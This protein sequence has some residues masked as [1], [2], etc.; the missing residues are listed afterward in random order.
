MQ[1]APVIAVPQNTA[2]VGHKARNFSL[3]VGQY[4]GRADDERRCV[5]LSGG[6]ECGNVGQGLDGF[7]KPHVIRQHT[8]NSSA[9]E[10]LQPIQTVLL[11]GA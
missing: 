10:C 5:Q 2:K 4:R 11:I 9:V 7:A 3:P 8:A 6:F 1:V